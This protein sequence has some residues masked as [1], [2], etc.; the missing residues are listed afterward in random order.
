MCFILEILRESAGISTGTSA[1]ERP[2]PLYGGGFFFEINSVVNYLFTTASDGK[3][4]KT[5]FYSLDAIL[6]VGFRVRSPPRHAVSSLG[7]DDLKELEKEVIS[8]TAHKK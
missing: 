2:S 4:Y 1:K 3:K 6:A 5:A 7:Q 8:I